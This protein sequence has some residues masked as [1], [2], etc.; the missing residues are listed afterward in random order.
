[1]DLTFP[2]Y[3]VEGDPYEVGFQH[4]QSANER[5]QKSLDIYRRAFLEMANIQ[6]AKA[7]EMGRTFLPIIRE[8]D[9][10]AIDEVRG[11]AEGANCQLE[12]IIALNSR[13]ELMFLTENPPEGCTSVSVL[14]EASCNGHT[15][16]GQNW[17]WKTECL[18]SAILL[19]IQRKNGLRVFYVVEAGGVGG[20]GM[21]SG[22][23]G[24]V[25][26]FLETDRD[27]KQIGVPLRF[28]SRKI[29][30]S[31]NMADAMKALVST[32]KTSSTNRLIGSRQ[33]VAIDLEA[34]PENF[35]VVYPEN[36]L[37]VHA[38]HFVSHIREIDTARIRFPDTLYRDWRMK[39]LLEPKRGKIA[40]KDLQE[41]FTDHL[42]YPRSICR[43]LD[44]ESKMADR[45]QTVG[46][47][48]MD[49]NEGDIRFAAGCPCKTEYE[50]FHLQVE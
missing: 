15:V 27:R 22:G 21:N 42:G 1:M 10:E 38:N 26:N 11:I 33:G 45:I 40:L 12:E 34:A 20:M 14:P 49:L 9:P 35:Y 48:I 44:P 18:E 32:K 4:G 41:S 50:P 30:S 3:K 39:Q 2:F 25:G 37:L 31:L 13:T 24:V 16:L 46:S 29:L 28:I 7:I 23:I 8:Y 36:G 5:I 47:I 6:W 43:H 19:Q 17:D